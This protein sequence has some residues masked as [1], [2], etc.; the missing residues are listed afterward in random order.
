MRCTAPSAGGRSRSG[1]A[2]RRRRRAARRRDAARRVEAARRGVRA[3]AV[4]RV[5]ERAAPGSRRA[6][7]RLPAA[8]AAGPVRGARHLDHR[9]AGLAVR[10]LRDPQPA[11][12]SASASRSGEAWAFPTRERIAAA[13]EDELVAVG[14][15][16]R[17]AE[18][19]IGL[20]RSDLDLDALAVLDDDEVRARDHGASRARPVDGRVV[21]RPAPRPAARLARRRPR[22]AQGG[23]RSLRLR[24]ERARP[25]PRPV[26]EP[27]RPLPAY[28][29]G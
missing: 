24:R 23:A 6:P 4:L 18:Y 21:P 27:L 26:P 28:R 29:D 12:S 5:G 2:G 20:A 17:K 15:S 8:A 10:G 9:A 13:T 11:R 25:A 19:A 3:R 16:R 1:R 7:A 22:P 14:F